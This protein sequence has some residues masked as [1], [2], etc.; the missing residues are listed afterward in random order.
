MA[1]KLNLDTIMKLPLSRKIIILAVVNIAIIG[2]LYWFLIGPKYDEIG[3]LKNDLSSLQ[4]KL[5][6]NRT[7]AS[8]IPRYLKEKEEMEARLN[9]AVAQ[10][11]NEKEIPDLIDSISRAGEKAG[12]K[13]LVFRPS[14]ETSRGFY[15]EVPVNMSVEGRFESLYDF[16][17]KVGS[18]PRIVNIENMNIISLGHRNKVPLLKANF[19]ATTFRFIPGPEAGAK[20]K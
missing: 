12:L 9:A 13:I 5:D 18:L 15:A 4:S 10:L 20:K 11:P 17:A 6:E 2:G 8:D 7:I 16:S 1:I 19:M 3:K 14:R